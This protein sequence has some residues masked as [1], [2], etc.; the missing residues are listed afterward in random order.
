MRVGD[1]VASGQVLLTVES[2]KMENEIRAE[3]DGTVA[4]LHVG[5]GDIVKVKQMMV[6]LD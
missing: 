5:P 2:M 4:E 1:R 3:R 6:V